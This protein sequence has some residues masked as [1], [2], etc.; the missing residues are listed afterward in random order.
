MQGE[1]DTIPPTTTNPLS[2]EE[3]VDP[4]FTDACYVEDDP[5]LP[6]FDKEE[7]PWDGFQGNVRREYL[8]AHFAR[9]QANIEIEDKLK[10]GKVMREA[11]DNA[12]K[13]GKEWG[14]KQEEEYKKKLMLCSVDKWKHSEEL[15][16]VHGNQIDK[17]LSMDKQCQEIAHKDSLFLDKSIREMLKSL[18]YEVIICLRTVAFFNIPIQEEFKGEGFFIVSRLISAGK[19]GSPGSMCEEDE[20]LINEALANP[21]HSDYDTDELMMSFYSFDVIAELVT[22][23][24]VDEFKLDQTSIIMKLAKS[25]FT[26]QGYDYSF[27]STSSV[28]GNV[29]V[30]DVIRAHNFAFTQAQIK[31]KS[32]G[33]K[34][35]HEVSKN[36]P[37]P[38]ECP[39]YC[40]DFWKQVKDCLTLCLGICCYCFK[41]CELDKSSFT[42]DHTSKG[43]STKLQSS[44]NDLATTE[45]LNDK[46]REKVHVDAV[47]SKEPYDVDMVVDTEGANVRIKGVELVYVDHVASAIIEGAVIFHPQVPMLEIMKLVS[48]LNVKAKSYRDKRN[49]KIEYSC[50][51]VGVNIMHE[52]T[53]KNSYWKK[54]RGQLPN[55]DNDSS[56]LIGFNWSLTISVE[57][58]Y[59]YRA[60]CG[61]NVLLSFI[62]MI[63]SA[64]GASEF[65]GS[66][67]GNSMAA[68]AIFVV[69]NMIVK[70][71]DSVKGKESTNLNF[72]ADTLG[73]VFFGVMGIITAGLQ[74]S[75]SSILNSSNYDDDRSSSTKS[76]SNDDSSVTATVVLLFCHIASLAL[77]ALVTVLDNTQKGDEEG[78]GWKDLETG[79]KKKIGSTPNKMS[80]KYFRGKVWNPTKSMT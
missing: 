57:P 35:S 19:N 17:A 23:A 56:A 3:Q 80:D 70:G 63:T 37:C 64:V 18:G 44:L 30:E 47:I 61:T 1:R 42:N 43:V 58:S 28:Y 52:G 50:R 41:D 51:D 62:A 45:E 65:Q 36:C 2:S 24:T 38:T 72:R 7:K 53:G 40:S 26:Y 6:P 71:Y 31:E 20:L 9:F 8:I 21:L 5:L 39:S 75:S 4:I 78:F 15:Q 12:L 33:S 46:K 29:A 66:G 55:Y 69:I 79:E 60:I 25:K 32:E 77:S 76:S 68:S 59:R 54:I 10:D 27:R 49:E 67:I 48:I 22:N 14:L 74:N 11:R 34:E 16:K 13:N 73:S